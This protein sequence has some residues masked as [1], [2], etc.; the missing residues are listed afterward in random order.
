M[1]FSVVTPSHNSER[2]IA[3][4]IESVVSQAG[5]FEIEYI[6]VD[7]ASTDRTAEIASGYAKRVA[8]GTYPVK[9]RGVSIALMSEPDEGMYDA[10]NWGFEKATG[11]V[12]AWI[13]SDDVY[14]ADAFQKV[15]RCFAA[16]PD[17][18]WL[19]GITSFIDAGSKVVARGACHLYCRE[20][21]RR[22]VQGRAWDWVEQDSVFW[23]ADLWREVGGC[24]ARLKTAGD[25]GLWMAFAEK[26]PLFSLNAE[27][28]CFRRVAGQ[29]SQDMDAYRSEMA[30]LSA[31]LDDDDTRIRR[32][33]AWEYRIPRRLRP[34]VFRRL[35]G[36]LEFNLLTLGR[37]D[38]VQ[39]HRG[40]Y[41]RLR[42]LL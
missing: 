18:R 39:R 37:G 11:D 2:F 23:R 26:T 5:D 40:T 31:G 21:L 24:D 34:L 10:I 14:R 38:E 17:V 1:K 33:F 32:F 7:N 12:Y 27:T 15:A 20:W 22:G 16:Y 4:T 8:E 36:P 30:V 35:F 42:A 28:S 19:K 6:V 41:H 3:E 25:Y 13:N 9:C 29:K